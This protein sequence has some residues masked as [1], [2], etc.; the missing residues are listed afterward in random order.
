MQPRIFFLLDRRIFTKN[1]RDSGGS[2]CKFIE[3]PK[4]QHHGAY[5]NLYSAQSQLPQNKLSAYIF[6]KTGFLTWYKY[7][8]V[9][10]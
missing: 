3:G 1:Y 6:T 8:S 2:R 4:H 10:G 7:G 5:L 9:A